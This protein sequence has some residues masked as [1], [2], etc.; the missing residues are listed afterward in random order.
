MIL[1]E[2]AKRSSLVTS[3][4]LLY[5]HCKILPIGIKQTKP[6]I[7][8]HQQITKLCYFHFLPVYKFY[9][10]HCYLQGHNSFLI[11]NEVKLS[12]VYLISKVFEKVN[13]LHKI[14]TILL[15]LSNR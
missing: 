6:G 11:T 14:F 9:L 1:L 12:K 8:Y 5:F 2:I 7:H 13:G 4:F 3:E 15:L 10:H